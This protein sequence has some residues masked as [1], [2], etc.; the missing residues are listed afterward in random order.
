MAEPLE[1]WTARAEAVAAWLPHATREALMA[2]AWREYQRAESAAYLVAEQIERE[3]LKAQREASHAV[4]GALDW[5]AQAGRPSYAELQRRR[6]E[7]A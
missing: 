7:V 3:E 5:T 6:G 1:Y 4:S 2:F